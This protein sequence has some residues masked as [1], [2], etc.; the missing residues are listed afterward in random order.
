VLVVLLNSG[1]HLVQQDLQINVSLC[2][3]VSIERT[4]TSA[5]Q[6]LNWSQENVITMPERLQG[7]QVLWN[8]NPE[9]TL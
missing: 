8:P 5:T 2:R 9:W 7:D 3:K 4:I 6:T 1:I